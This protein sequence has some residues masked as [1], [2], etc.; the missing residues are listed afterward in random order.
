MTA[1]LTDYRS[2]LAPVAPATSAVR[3]EGRLFTADLL[4]RVAAGDRELP[5]CAPADYGLYRGERIGDAAGRAWAAL[6]GAYRAFRDDLARL[7]GEKPATTLT[8]RAWLLR[9]FTELGYGP[10]HADGVT[11]EHPTRGERLHVSHR[12]QDHLPVH[13]LAWGKTL[14]RKV[15]NRRAP[16]S[17]LQEL[18]NVSP[19]HLWGILSNGQLL[20][21]VRDSTSL[22]GSA[23]L[24]FDLEAIFDNGQYADF[25]LLYSLLHATRFELVAKPRKRRRTRSAE[26][27]EAPDTAG[28]TAEE[29]EDGTEPEGDE[30]EP[31]NTGDTS[32]QQKLGEDAD[33][34]EAPALTS[35]DCRI[36]W[37]RAHSVET[38]L[39]ARDHLRDQ[40][41]DALGVLGT[42]FLGANPELREVVARGGQEALEEL[43]HELLRL[44]YQLIFLFVAEDRGILLDPTDSPPVNDAR[45]RYMEYFSTRRLRRIAFRRPGDRNT[46]L[47][48]ALCRVLDALGT[49]GGAPALALPELGGLYFRAD[50]ESAPATK[51]RLGTAEPLRKADLP[52]EQLL[53]AVRLLCRVQDKQ[54]RWQRVD[55]RHLGADELGSVYESLLELRPRRTA[56]PERFWV[57][58]LAGNKRKTTGAYYTPVTVI[59]KLLDE[60][61]D[62]VIERFAT[63]DPRRLLDLRFVDPACGSG[64]VL[65][66]AARRIAHR[67]AELDTGDP[68]PAPERVR[69]ALAEV[70]RHCV[71]GVD[72][73]PMAVEIAKVSLWLESLEPGRPLA[74]LDDRVKTGNALLGTTPKLIAEGLPDGA[75]KK[76]AGDDG[77]IL[78]RLKAAN[79]K[80]LS[81]GQGTQ[82][83][84][85]SAPLRMGTAKLRVEAD[86]LADLPD[87]SLADVREQARRYEAFVRKS[88]ERQRHQRVADA[89]CAAFL[90]PKYVGAPVALTSSTLVHIAEGG[91]LPPDGEEA[92]QNIASRNQFFHWHL[93]FPRVFRVENDEDEDHNP[94]TG[95][96]GGF[97]CVLGNPP[98]ERVK[99]QEKEWFASRDETIADALNAHERK[100]LIA[101]L[102]ESEDHVDREHYEQFQIA[103]REAAGTT[104]MLRSSGI[105]PLTGH[106]DVNTYAVFAERAR[107]LLAPQGLSGLV[108]PTGIATDLTTARFFGDLV[109]RRQLVA[110][111]DMENEEKLFP[112]VTNRYSFCLFT[113]C[114]PGRRQERA[115]L[116]F[117]ARRPDQLDARTFELDAEGFRDINPNTRTSPV[118]DSREH[119]AVLRGIHERVPVLWEKA[120]T[121]G[122]RNPWGLRFQAMFH[123]SG[124]S[125]LF[126]LSETLEESGWTRIDTIYVNEGKRALPLY[127]GKFIHQYDARFATYRDATQ[128]QINKGTLPRLDISAHRD[129]YTVPLPRYWVRE[130]T[131]DD[132]LAA[133]DSLKPETEWPCDWLMGWRNICRASDERTVIASAMPRSA[134]GDTVPLLLPTSRELPLEGLLAN[135]CAFVLDFAARQKISGAHLTYTY[136]EQLPVL[137][138]DKYTAPVPWLAG[139]PLAAWI[140]TRVLELTY[141]SHELASFARYLGDE[142]APFVWDDERRFLMRAEL[143]AAYFHLYGVSEAEAELVLDSFRAFR[144]KKPVLFERTKEEIL[145]VY[146]AMAKASESGVRY[147]HPELGP[148]PGRG[149]RHE[150][151]WSPLTR[152]RAE[153][154]EETREETRE[155]GPSQPE[156]R[157]PGPADEDDSDGQ[158]GLWG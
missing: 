2:P 100:K 71:H 7:S 106:G 69:T 96:Q 9:L 115:R 87:G 137:S 65:V 1:P 24:E 123:M 28:G 50:D 99:I 109:E 46:D 153:A 29:D 122:E 135:L 78:A 60:A 70:V 118:C 19:G 31:G 157:E 41:A 155:E 148:A 6:T 68:E 79:K 119:L 138:P 149:P 32:G 98:W 128:A 133:E 97:D 13:L 92:L 85:G 107:T 111:L 88:E 63:G 116:A 75:F 15:G 126:L 82:G 55:Y 22:V 74:Y 93:E 142:G 143:D 108:L 26:E 84:L 141:T 105:F 151:G 10:L 57:Q 77:K 94:L 25:V 112:D 83:S 95:W 144:N 58:T 101:A 67:Y 21:V 3:I 76:L 117:R 127:E 42:G 152:L 113:I 37:L 62:P 23:Y 56:Q 39:R 73:N 30:E 114:G 38:G 8:R 146:R 150:P 145:A 44:V 12:W 156:V 134:M 102:S 121:G 59:E 136:L 48:P 17:V 129:P 53:E 43:H 110:V 18:L 103:L 72:I 34:P 5:G 61:L 51:T 124:A 147:A 49:D 130:E 132:R 11:V 36:E 91:S 45:K 90:W 158:L 47:W 20:R 80:E 104:L 52:N 140:R 125:E 120:G 54:L 86:E 40:V 131:V 35:A 66:A 16:Q 139:E 4:A 81:G 154:G 64:H 89:W 33:D 27:T 14:D